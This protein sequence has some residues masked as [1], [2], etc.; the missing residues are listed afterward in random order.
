[1]NYNAEPPRDGLRL[2]LNE[3]GYALWNTALQPLLQ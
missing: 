2:H 3:N 1:M